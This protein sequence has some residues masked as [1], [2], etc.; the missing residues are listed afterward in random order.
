[1]QAY[2]REACANMTG[3]Q[4]AMSPLDGEHSI[5]IPEDWWLF[6]GM[7]Q[8]KPNDSGFY[9]Y[10]NTFSDV[11]VLPLTSIESPIRDSGLGDF[12]MYKLVP[13]LWAFRTPGCPIPPILV[14]RISVPGKHQ[15]RVRDGIYR[16]LA[17]AACGYIKIPAR[18]VG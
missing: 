10:G 3:T 5:A 16:L 2:Q 1:M 13:V 4:V 9:L 14:E 8:F 7:S 11:E 17:S 12:R 6:A 15:Y 18:I